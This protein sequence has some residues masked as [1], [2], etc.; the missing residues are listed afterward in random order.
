MTIL[1]DKFLLTT[2]DFQKYVPEDYITKG[3]EKLSLTA[4]FLITDRNESKI[5]EY[6]LSFAHQKELIIL[7]SESF[8][9]LNTDLSSTDI[10]LSYSHDSKQILEP[11]ATYNQIIATDSELAVTFQLCKVLSEKEC[12]TYLFNSELQKIYQ[13]QTLNEI[14]SYMQTFRKYMNENFCIITKDFMDLTS[15]NLLPLALQNNESRVGS[16]INFIGVSLQGSQF[17][18]QKRKPIFEALIEELNTV[19]NS[20]IPDMNLK[21]VTLRSELSNNNQTGDVIEVVS[22]RNGQEIP[23]HYESE[24]IK[25]LLTILNLLIYM[26]NNPNVFVAIDELDASIFEYLLGEI[27]SMLTESGK[28]HLNF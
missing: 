17:I 12:S 27:L 7:E 25:K 18:E 26:H 1:G 14:Y 8:K 5:I 11:A 4:R 21:M 19:I 22:V 20:I 6:T 28:G 9:L 23:L 24:G 3:K 15:L 2:K 10:F 13:T 16:F